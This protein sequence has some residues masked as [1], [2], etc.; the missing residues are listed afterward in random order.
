LRAGG[1]IE[2][3]RRD[4]QREH[5]R[6]VQAA[7]TR[8]VGLPADALSLL[9]LHAL[10]LQRDLRRAVAR[11]AGRSIEA[12]AHLADSLAQLDAALA[13]TMLRQ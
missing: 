13:A 7:L 3:L 6:R 10:A 2:R 4:L 5:L 8:P 12:R 1:D 9:R 11:P